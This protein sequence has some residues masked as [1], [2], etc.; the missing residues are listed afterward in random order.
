MTTIEQ[1]F[2]SMETQ[3]T[4]VAVF[5]LQ[6]V[7]GRPGLPSITAQESSL[8]PSR[9]SI[10][11]A[12]VGIELEMLMSAFQMSFR[13]LFWQRDVFRRNPARPFYWTCH[14]RATHNHRRSTDA[15]KFVSFLHPRTSNDRQICHCPDWFIYLPQLPRSEGF[16]QSFNV[17]SSPLSLP[18][19]MSLALILLQLY[20]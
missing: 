15:V 3:M 18:Y 19:G 20:S 17:D 2:A 7:K 5:V 16:W 9:F 13:L 1:P 14:Q 4:D 11:S 8:K 12:A 6:M 10:V